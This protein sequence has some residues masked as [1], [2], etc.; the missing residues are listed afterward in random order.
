MLALAENIFE[1]GILN[2]SKE[3]K[4]S[5]FEKLKENMLITN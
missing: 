5:L 4:E 2:L 1:A 3:L